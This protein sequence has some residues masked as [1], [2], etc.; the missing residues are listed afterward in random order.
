MHAGLAHTRDLPKVRTC[1]VMGM[2]GVERHKL[3]LLEHAA[4]CVHV[5]MVACVARMPPC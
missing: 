3:Q 5:H 1:D 4:F 2:H